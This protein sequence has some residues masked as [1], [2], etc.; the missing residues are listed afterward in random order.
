MKKIFTTIFSLAL[1]IIMV[2]SLGN[3]VIDANGKDRYRTITTRDVVIFGCLPLGNVLKV[4]VSSHRDDLDAE[5]V[6]TM[7]KPCAEAVAG[8]A[9]GGYGVQGIAADF[10]VG[11]T[12]TMVKKTRTRV[13]VANNQKNNKRDGDDDDDDDDDN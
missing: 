8:L 11:L 2:S 4:A 5:L 10:S 13:P 3:G 9:N 6:P 12:Y 7:S 1:A